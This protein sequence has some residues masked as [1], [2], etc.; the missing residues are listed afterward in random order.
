MQFALERAKHSGEWTAHL[1]NPLRFLAAQ[2]AACLLALLLCWLAGARRRAA[3][4]AAARANG[5]FCCCR[6][7]CAVAHC[8]GALRRFLAGGFAR[9]G[10]A[11]MPAFLPL[12]WFFFYMP[13]PRGG[14]RVFARA[15]LAV[16]LAALLAAASVNFFAPFVAE[17]GKRVHTP[18]RALGEG[19]ERLWRG[20]F[21]NLPLQYVVGNKH[22]AAAAAFYAPSRPSAILGEDWQKNFW[23]T[24]KQVAA[25]GGVF[26]W[27]VDDG[28]RQNARPPGFAAQFRAVGAARALTPAR[29][30]G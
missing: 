2:L 11:A 1:L 7:F 8:L 19:V 10:G 17:R 21:A 23:A 26:V 4:P 16:A 30:M 24:P 28:K 18:G 20:H 15:V 3:L 25:A 13:A 6:G 12:F 27:V 29:N 9:C 22:T 14:R 5:G